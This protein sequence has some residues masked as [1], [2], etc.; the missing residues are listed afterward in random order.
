MQQL[1]DLPGVQLS[2]CSGGR[3]NES[4]FQAEVSVELHVERL[5][6]YLAVHAA[7]FRY[8]TQQL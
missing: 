5:S 2:D 7:L 1:V 3:P 8:P 4:V 6:V